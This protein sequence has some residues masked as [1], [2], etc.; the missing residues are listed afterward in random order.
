MLKILKISEDEILK[1]DR[2][3]RYE[4]IRELIYAINVTP[5]AYLG[6]FCPYEVMHGRHPNLLVSP[7]ELCTKC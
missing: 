7:D 6:W 3:V 2:N 1:L 4:M 5:A